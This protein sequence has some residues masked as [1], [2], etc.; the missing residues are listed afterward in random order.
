MSDYGQ[1][2]VD[3]GLERLRGT[4]TYNGD[5]YDL[6]VEDISY[7][8]FKLA[9]QY[10]ALSAQL[11]EIEDPEDVDADALTEQAEALG[12]FSWEDDGENTDFI[13]GMI[14]AK[15]VKPDVDIHNTS[16]A[17]LRA[18]VEGMMSTWGEADDV[19]AARDEMPLEGNA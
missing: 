7:P 5:E 6:L 15:L 19:A 16:T 1:E 9:Q 10:G 14:D 11:A 3:R 4:W 13:P 8:D 18:L 2:L 17:K 12:Q